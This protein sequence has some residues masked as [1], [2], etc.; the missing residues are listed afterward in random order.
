MPEGLPTDMKLLPEYLQEQGYRTHGLG[1]WHLGFCSP[2]YT[3]TR[4]GFHTFDG[5]YVGD[6]SEVV[7]ASSTQGDKQKQDERR[8]ERQMHRTIR[9][10]N[11][12]IRKKKYLKARNKVKFRDQPIKNFFNRTT[13]EEFDSLAYAEKAVELIKDREDDRPFFIYLS[14]LTKVYPDGTDISSTLHLRRLQKVSAHSVLCDHTSLYIAF[15]VIIQVY[16]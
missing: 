8:N 9:K 13:Q 10:S 15:C 3:P 16:I 5:L 11:S 4:R 6:K 7:G 14:L 1:K 12:L 2:S